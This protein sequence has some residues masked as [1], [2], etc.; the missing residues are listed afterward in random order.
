MCDFTTVNENKNVKRSFQAAIS[1]I[2][3]GTYILNISCG[4]YKSAT[5]DEGGSGGYIHSE[6]LKVIPYT[7]C[8]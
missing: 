2:Y 8:F 5:Q 3:C 1:Y 4:Y 7:L 6:F